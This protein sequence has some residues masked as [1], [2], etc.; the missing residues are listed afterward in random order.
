MTAT[1]VVCPIC[2]VRLVPEQ[3]LGNPTADE[4]TWLGRC[5]NQHW[6]LQ[7]LVFGCIPI[8]PGAIAVDGAATATEDE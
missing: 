8:D 3:S 7:S 2:G 5:E 6:W 4:S 1:E